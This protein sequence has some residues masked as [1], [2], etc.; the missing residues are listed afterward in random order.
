MAAGLI[1]VP[2]EGQDSGPFKM[3]SAI[4]GPVQGFGQDSFCLFIATQGLQHASAL[5][6][7]AHILWEVL[8]E[9]LKVGQC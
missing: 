6:G 8:L 2:L 4:V 7:S 3:N 5:K 1:G 9:A